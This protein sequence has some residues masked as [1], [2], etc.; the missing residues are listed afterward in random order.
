MGTT[1]ED[2]IRLIFGL[3]VA[4]ERAR[5]GLSLSALSKKAGLSASYLNEIEKGKKYPKAE[6]II[7]LAQ[8]LEVEYDE[9]VST[10]LK[11]DLAPLGDLMS[12]KIFDQI[13]FSLFGIDTTQIVELLS[14]SPAQASSFLGA[15]ME[16]ARHYNI[17]ESEVYTAALRSYQE[18]ANN[19]F[20]DIEQKAQKFAAQHNFNPFV[21]DADKQ[22]ERLL[23]N[24]FSYQIDKSTLGSNDLLKGVKSYYT[25]ESGPKLFIEPE[26]SASQQ[27][28]LLAKELGFNVLDLEKTIRVN[29]ILG[30]PRIKSFQQ[31]L[32]N[33]QASY[34]AGALLLPKKEVEKD[35]GLWFDQETFDASHLKKLSDKWK[36]TPETLFHRLTNILPQSFGLDVLFFL[37]FNQ[38]PEEELPHLERELHLNRKHLPHATKLG[39][40][41][42]ARWSAL[43]TLKEVVG[44]EGGEQFSAHG[45]ISEF[46]ENGD[47]YLV[48]SMGRKIS[49]ATGLAT[50]TCL[51][52]YLNAKLKRKVRWLS[53]P[54]LAKKQVNVL[55]ENCAMDCEDRL[56]PPSILERKSL[57]MEVED[58]LSQL[59]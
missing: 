44:N 27:I 2:K 23:A 53:D 14:K 47:C 48:I 20:P 13:P 7:T 33:L 43:K 24:L 59:H 35:L 49:E 45:Q 42:C 30:K 38:K 4:Q 26:L 5:L 9:L 15:F 21:K 37:K 55:C 36:C 10:K 31:I 28:F 17:S 8:A 39:A 50:S 54:K 3:K 51:G 56:A 16:I 11:Q 58:A 32:I 1:S 6:K 41:Y 34:F 40:H 18:I 25:Q 22:L 12:S 19:Y 46:V 52:I 29:T 57:K